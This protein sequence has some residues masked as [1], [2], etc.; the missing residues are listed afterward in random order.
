MPTSF[1][2]VVDR[3]RARETWTDAGRV[4]AAAPAAI[5]QTV[6]TM[7]VVIYTVALTPIGVG[8]VALPFVRIAVTRR[9]A[10][11]RARTGL[12]DRDDPEADDDRGPADGRSIREAIRWALSTRARREVGFLLA[13]GP[14][15]L[16]TA[17]LVLAIFYLIGRALLEASFIVVWPSALHGAWG[18][19]VVGAL[20][21]H[22]GPGVVAG[23][24][25]TRPIR[26]AG[27]L[28]PRVARALLR[29]V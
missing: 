15:A 21:V 13:D 28:Q 8:L 27:S 20:V 26:W 22:C 6:A 24:W 16:L 7:F 12:R 9:A 25:G 19:S 2:E 10:A 11:A 1:V 4:L 14:I 3:W 29:R 5:V 18:G 17:L 23:I